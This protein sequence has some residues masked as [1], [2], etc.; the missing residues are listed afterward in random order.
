M[1]L[2]RI[3]VIILATAIPMT[4]AAQVAHDGRGSAMQFGAG[5]TYFPSF[6]DGGDALGFQA[7]LRMG[8]TTGAGAEFA[9]TYVPSSTSSP[10]PRLHGFRAMYTL[11]GRPSDASRLS[12]ALAVGGSLMHMRD[13]GY[14]CPAPP[15]MCEYGAIQ[16]T[17]IAPGGG[18]DVHYAANRWLGLSARTRVHRA[19]G[20]GWRGEGSPWLTELSVGFD[21]RL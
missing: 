4:A 12:Y 13:S 6:F 7:F 11:S 10:K 19:I 20:D 3:L 17:R 16:G 8:P 2:L 18:L 5:G 1:S 21:F 15:A 9:Y 14:A